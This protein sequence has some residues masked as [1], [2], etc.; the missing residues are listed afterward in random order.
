MLNNLTDLLVHEIRDLYSAETQLVDALPKMAAAAH[1]EDLRQ[2]FN[3]H[4]E[5]TKGHVDRLADA[6]R[7][8]NVSPTGQ[9]CE[10]MKGLI[11]ESSETINE[12]ADPT[13]K[14]A[15]LIAAYGSAACF[16]DAVD[17]GD[18]KKLLGETLSEEKAADELLNKIATGGLFT[19]GVNKEAA[20]Q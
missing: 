15:A 7:L 10:A 17:A 9:T 5:E 6:A 11:R 16:A 14:D 3:E 12:L 19:S 1:D 13:V 8:L 4:L 18:V 20:H 2:A